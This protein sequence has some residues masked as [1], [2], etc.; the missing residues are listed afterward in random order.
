[1]G[2]LSKPTILEALFWIAIAGIFFC[3]TFTFNQP[4][5]IYKFGATGWPRVILL[6]I[7]LVAFGNLYYNFINGSKVQQDRVGMSDDPDDVS[8]DSFDTYLKTG[9]ILIIPFL[10][11][12]SLKPVGFYCAT[13]IFIALIMY[14]W[15][16]R[17]FKFILG[18]TVLIYALLLVLFMLALNAPLPQG[19]ISPFYDVSAF[20]LKMKTQF[21]QLF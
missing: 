3:Y 2:K 12:L 13:P 19:N 17:R 5:E 6:L 1:M 18:N 20:L 8:Y 21:D 7:L 14:A 10:Y 4:I 16:E 15:G 9:F 11:A